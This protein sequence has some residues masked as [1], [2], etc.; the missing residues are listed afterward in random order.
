[1]IELA[2]A[3]ANNPEVL[4]GILASLGGL[5]AIFASNGFLAVAVQKAARL[6]GR[7]VPQDVSVVLGL[8]TWALL[9]I[10]R[11]FSG[12]TVAAGG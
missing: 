3:E 1:M 11:S 12:S 2:E 7:S 4:A 10:A 8:V 9:L 5:T 6:M